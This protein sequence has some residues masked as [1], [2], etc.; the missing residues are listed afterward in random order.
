MLSATEVRTCNSTLAPMRSIDGGGARTLPAAAEPTSAATS[1]SNLGASIASAFAADMLMNCLPGRAPD[2]HR[3]SANSW[4]T[5]D[6]PVPGL[7]TN[8][9]KPDQHGRSM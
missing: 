4:A 9:E 8:A 3:M 1:A 7:P 6:L 5:V 2:M